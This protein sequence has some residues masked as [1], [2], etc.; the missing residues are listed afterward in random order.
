M[1][2]PLPQDYQEALQNPRLCFSDPDL[3]SSSPRLDVLGLPKPI[4]G[5]FAS[6]YE[7]SL[8]SKRWAVRCFL[9][10]FR[11]QQSRYEAITR[12]LQQVA[13]PCTVDF[14]FESQGIMIRGRWYPIL[15]MEWID[16][17][18]LA[19]FIERNLQNPSALKD[20]AREWLQVI[21]SLK[22]NRIAHGDLQ[23]GNILIS[24]NKIRLIDYDGMFVPALAG[25]ESHEV[26]HRNYQHP[27]R[28]AKHFGLYLD[29]FSAWAIYIS[30]VSVSLQ[31]TLWKQLHA[32]ESQEKLL[33]NRDDFTATGSSTVFDTLGRIRQVQIQT[34]SASFHSMI[35]LD[36]KDVPFLDGTDIADEHTPATRFLPDW[37]TPNEITQH[38]PGTD[39]QF[40]ASWVL[41]HLPRKR[42][43][44][45][46]GHFYREK[47][48][49]GTVIGL[50]SLLIFCFWRELIPPLV[51]LPSF[52]LLTA[53]SG[54]TFTYLYRSYPPVIRKNVF[55]KQKKIEVKDKRR[56]ERKIAELSAILD[57]ERK[58]AEKNLVSLGKK[59]KNV[60]T[61]YESTLEALE[62]KYR[63]NKNDLNLRLDKVNKNA[64]EEIQRLNAQRQASLA[65]L[66]KKRQLH[67]DSRNKE[68]TTALRRQQES[69]LQ[70]R[71]SAVPLDGAVITGIGAKL[72]NRLTS[73]GIRCAADLEYRK[74]RR[75]EGIGNV[76][77]HALISWRKQVEFDLLSA[78]GLQ[79]LDAQTEAAITSKY[80]SVINDSLQE[81]LRVNK[82]FDDQE[83]KSNAQWQPLR[84]GIGAELYQLEEQAAKSMQELK[85]RHA[86][87]IKESATE[88]EK[89]RCHTATTVA[90]L[91]AK[92][93]LERKALASMTFKLANLDA[94]LGS[95]AHITAGA[96][97]RKIITF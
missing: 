44:S 86:Q 28:S 35:F 96:Y 82:H 78:A 49:L 55:V 36:P 94:N 26:G 48:I 10:E 95:H 90:D 61:K 12:H 39:R 11:D 42:V 83:G 54:L 84:H 34:L 21:A 79:R 3:Q 72:I 56:I 81:E 66:L 52:L 64:R 18:P 41:D 1:G 13:I 16:G 58:K 68:L 38:K 89:A 92:I 65:T 46:D 62:K 71:L 6:V 60:V 70:T 24:N 14:K 76:K 91:N 69:Y 85:V 30:I 22:S 4:T 88:V 15:K 33:F 74:V 17:I 7:V 2:W 51:A 63:S 23:H 87:D 50:T 73:S 29:N 93:G 57:L 43:E 40:D 27:S 77:A 19:V 53:G 25:F 47:A 5:A 75:V 37:L 45:I 31:P 80:N 67:I 20:L 59:Q 32:G 8:N 9:K 97:M